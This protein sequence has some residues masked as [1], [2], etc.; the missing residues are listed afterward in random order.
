VPPPPARWRVARRLSPLPAGRDP[1][2]TARPPPR[3]H[4]RTDF[5]VR[6]TTDAVTGLYHELLGRPRPL[7]QERISR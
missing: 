7:N 3:Q 1:R 4:A 2:P 5:D 6:R